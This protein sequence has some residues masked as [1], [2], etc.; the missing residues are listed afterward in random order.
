MGKRI[1]QKGTND[2]IKSLAGLFYR[3]PW[4]PRVE[5]EVVEVNH[6][7]QL[8]RVNLVVAYVFPKGSS[9]SVR[10]NGASLAFNEMPDY[11]SPFVPTEKEETVVIEF[12]FENNDPE[13]VVR[14]EVSPPG[15]TYSLKAQEVT[16][17]ELKPT[18]IHLPI[19]YKLDGR[20]PDSALKADIVYGWCFAL[21]PLQVTKIQARLDETSLSVEFPLE[22]EDIADNFSDQED[23]NKC[24]FE[25][26]LP[27]DKTDGTI[28]LEC[29]CCT[30]SRRFWWNSKRS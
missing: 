28:T 12:T 16:A 10:I 17:G 30:M 21:N 5:A 20:F 29:K 22:R 25:C 24:G 19:L 3:L 15:K 27:P 23:S 14:L 7:L 13:T 4:T 6:W 1:H 2:M 18:S 9:P 11:E 26:E 8:K